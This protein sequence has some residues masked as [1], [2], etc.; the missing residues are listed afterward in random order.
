MRI[1]LH[2]GPDAQSSARLQ[3]VMDA[4]RRQM[5]K[6]GVLYARS[7]GARNHTRLFM[8][9]SD[10]GA[11]DALRWGRG[12][13]TPARQEAL[14][15]EVAAQ[16]AAEVESAQPDMLLL[17]AH[18]LGSGLTTQ[19][20]LA[21]LRA[22]LAP[23]SEDITVVAHLDAP[24][25]MLARHYAAQLLEGRRHGLDL[26]LG[27]C[28]APDWWQ[29]AL[30]TRP[31]RDPRGGV[32][33]EA[34]G[35][36]HWLDFARLQRG[37]EAAFGPGAVR[38]RSLDPA[39]LCGAEVTEE[40]RAAFEIGQSIGKV[41]AVQP[42]VQHSAAWLSR[43]R[44]MND[45]L[46]RYLAAEPELQI[47]RPLWRRLLGEIKLPGA[48][49]DPGALEA[50]NRRFAPDLAG[51]IAQHPGLDPAHLRPDPATADWQEA[52]P[53]F[54]FRATQYLMAF[55]WRIEQAAKEA[56]K[57]AGASSPTPAALVSE[58]APVLPDA[59]LRKLQALQGSPW[60]PHNRLG[61]L[62]ETAAMPPFATVPPRPRSE[63]GPRV[64]LGCM[65]NE[66]PYIVEWIAYHRAIGFDDFLIYSNGCEDGTDRIL[67]RLEQMG[68]LQH[69]DNN[70]W[71]GN[72]PQQHALD[73]AL[74]EELIRTARWMLHS[75]VDEFV[76]IRCGNGTLDDLFA[77]APEATHFALTWRLFGH[78]GVQ[79]LADAPV[80]GQFSACAPRYCPK[81]H[82]TWGFKTLMRGVGAYEK[83]SCHRPN[84]LRQDAETEVKWVNGSS[85]DM[86]SEALRNGWRNSRKSIGYDLVQLNHYALRSAESYLIKRQRGRALHVDRQIGLNYWIRMDWSGARD[87][88]IQR[89]LPRLRAEMGRLLADPELARLHAEGVAWHREKAAELRADPEFGKLFREATTLSLTPEERVAWA[90]SLDMES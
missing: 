46:L 12:V 36:V 10:P 34:Q 42:P 61:A 75:D 8:A 43:C 6:R 44:R 37:W 90:L 15:A 68:L 31:A 28:T 88:T 59:A 57:E 29:A 9:V 39:Q 53:G 55:R 30:G 49:L 76:N 66:A 78:D 84:K 58:V 3:Q 17:S 69:R 89:N 79:S 83:L 73:A 27:L 70:S 21:R 64:I 18:Q 71:S 13:D 62:D 60:L 40:I 1:L 33:P 23:L 11:V 85:R 67:E 65:K 63:S 82:T 81:P 56:A 87:L 48:P 20:E 80:I 2:I 50:V 22:L 7:P 77:A 19:A 41:E 5:A 74:D 35:A 51:L 72:S 52:D 47:P 14:R 86:T 25:R 38:L 4:K 45:V 54:G 26:E 32:F 16:L 24:A